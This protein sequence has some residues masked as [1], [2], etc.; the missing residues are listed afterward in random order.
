MTTVLAKFKVLPKLIRG[1]VCII[2]DDNSYNLY[3]PS[4]YTTISDDFNPLDYSLLTNTKYHNCIVYSKKSDIEEY[5]VNQQ[6]K[7]IEN[8]K[9]QIVTPTEKYK[10]GDSIHLK[11][12]DGIY[13]I[14]DIGKNNLVI[15]CNKWQVE[16]HPLHLVSRHDFHC[17]A[18][19]L[20]NLKHI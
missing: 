7:E 18:G 20:Y 5:L 15:T 14:V 6:L 13:K 3:N 16:K 12:R 8:K 17:L 10:I 9:Q 1:K 19:G 4:K 2:N 11:S